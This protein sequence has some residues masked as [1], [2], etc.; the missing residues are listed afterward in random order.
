MET[1]RSIQKRNTLRSSSHE[2]LPI[3]CFEIEGDDILIFFWRIF[4]ILHGP[5]GSPA[6]PGGM[7]PHVRVVRRALE[8]D[9][10]RH[11]EAGFPCFAHKRVEIG[12]RSEV[13]MEGLV[14]PSNDPMAQG[15]PGS[16]VFGDDGVV[17]PLSIRH[18]DRVNWREI[19]D[20]EAHPGNLRQE[21]F[22]PRQRAVSA[23]FPATGAG[24]IRTTPRNRAPFDPPRL[25]E[26]FRWC[27]QAIPGNNEPRGREVV[28]PVPRRAAWR[29]WWRNRAAVQRPSPASRSGPVGRVPL[30]GQARLRISPSTKGL[31]CFASLLQVLTP[32]RK[33]IDPAAHRVVVPP[34][35]GHGKCGFPAVISRKRM[36]TS[37]QSSSLPDRWRSMA[38]TTS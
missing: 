4:G 9:I 2:R 5:V 34:R 29:Y 20:V 12:D 16:S 8:G 26:L 36:G 35:S 11:C 1:P 17:S 15:E 31:S 23:G 6:K 22:A 25:P 7:I 14:P 19:D 30:H 24:K 37:C 18:A 27:W 10:H 33:V 38:A 13:G 28:H 32:G 21:F 3:L